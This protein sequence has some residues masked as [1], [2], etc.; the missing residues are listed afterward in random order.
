MRPTQA[1]GVAEQDEH[2]EIRR[3]IKYAINR[4]ITLLEKTSDSAGIVKADNIVAL[5]RVLRS[6]SAYD[7]LLVSI[8]RMKRPGRKPLQM[9]PETRI[10]VL[11]ACYF[12]TQSDGNDAAWV[13][14][15]DITNAALGY[16]IYTGKKVKQ[17]AER[18][19]RRLQTRQ[20]CAAFL[21]QSE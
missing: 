5:K 14:I 21:A 2:L 4:A 15:A 11:L 13:T 12:R 6:V 7:N 20:D 18:Y 9:G 19:F 8:K 17:K 10:I 3:K 1:H 16:N